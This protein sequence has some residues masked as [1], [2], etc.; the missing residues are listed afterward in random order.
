MA[1][2]RNGEVVV[3]YERNRSRTG[4]SGR[5]ARKATSAYL[6]VGGSS[7]TYVVTISTAGAHFCK[8]ET[9]EVCKGNTYG[10]ARKYGSVHQRDRQDPSQWCKHVAAALGEPELIAEAQE[11]TAEA[12]GMV[13]PEPKPKAE[14]K[15]EPFK[16]ER[17]RLAEIDRERERLEA[18]IAAETAESVRAAIKALVS[19]HG[20][21]AVGRVIVDEFITSD[22]S[23]Y[24][25]G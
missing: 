11:I 24:F 13:Q 18:L 20:E 25:H 23:T 2:L 10:K 19:E 3:D 15:A 22:G 17:E 12:F 16:A 6:L 7:G 1:H 5:R 4:D 8:T 21:D 9:G 14:P